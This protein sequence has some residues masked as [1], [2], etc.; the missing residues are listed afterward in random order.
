MEYKY[1]RAN[2]A[3]ERCGLVGRIKDDKNDMEYGV[4]GGV[5]SL[6]AIGVILHILSSK[7]NFYCC[8]L[9]ILDL[10]SL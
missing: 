5:E 9:R 7:Q 8:K 1:D 10:Y 6:T 2:E 4:V 3:M